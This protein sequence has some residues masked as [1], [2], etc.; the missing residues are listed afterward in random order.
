[1]RAKSEDSYQEK[2]NLGVRDIRMKTTC[3]TSLDNRINQYLPRLVCAGRLAL[4]SST[5]RSTLSFEVP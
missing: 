1:M 2:R 3:I 5:L 4:F